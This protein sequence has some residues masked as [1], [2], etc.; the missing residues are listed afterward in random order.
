MNVKYAST[1]P[2]LVLTRI[3]S[4]SAA[5]YFA[6]LSA[7]FNN[8]L[9]DLRCTANSSSSLEGVNERPNWHQDKKSTNQFGDVNERRY[10]HQGS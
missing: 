10:L 2:V 4:D 1:F 6:H 3:S 8:D 7:A 5:I 9:D